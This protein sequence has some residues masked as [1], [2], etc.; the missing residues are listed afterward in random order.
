L[1]DFFVHRTYY[2]SIDYQRNEVESEGFTLGFE[3]KE[4]W[5]LIYK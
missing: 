4:E 3:G 2:Y 1:G 5:E